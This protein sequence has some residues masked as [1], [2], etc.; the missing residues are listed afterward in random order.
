MTLLVRASNRYVD[1][2]HGVAIFRMRSSEVA[3]LSRGGVMN[4]LPSET[5]SGLVASSITAR[6]YARCESRTR[7]DTWSRESVLD[8][9]QDPRCTSVQG[10]QKTP[11]HSER[12]VIPPN[13]ILSGTCTLGSNNSTCMSFN[14]RVE[15]LH[16]SP[17]SRGRFV[18]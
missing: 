11:E 7:S 18:H 3:L 5:P 15:S 17:V 10:I 9:A 13:L 8:P 4:A 1:S 16:A 12:V 2:R 14:Y 6:R